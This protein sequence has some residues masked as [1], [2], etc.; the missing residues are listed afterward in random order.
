VAEPL[1]RLDRAGNRDVEPLD[2]VDL[3]RYANKTGS[4]VGPL[5]IGP[6]RAL[7]RKR[8]GLVP[9]P[10]NRDPRHSRCLEDRR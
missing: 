9:E 7:W 6:M 5:E 3:F 2:R 8:V 4:R 10:A 1:Q